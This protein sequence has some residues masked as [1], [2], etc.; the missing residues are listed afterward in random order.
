MTIGKYISS[1]RAKLSDDKQPYHVATVEV[2]D[3]LTE[4]LRRARSVRPSLGYQDGVLVP[5]DTEV[6]FTAAVST[7]V[8]SALDRYSEALVLI[9]AARLLV[10]DNA[11]TMNVA[12]AEKWREQGMELLGI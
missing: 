3:S 9:A 2:T 4:A 5:D 8:R 1:V 11:D 6:D 10:A 12:L 7:V